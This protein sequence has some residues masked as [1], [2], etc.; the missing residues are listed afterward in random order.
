MRVKFSDK[1]HEMGNIVEPYLDEWAQLK[2]NS[3]EKLKNYIKNT[4]N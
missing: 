1:V 2:P 3:P 4:L